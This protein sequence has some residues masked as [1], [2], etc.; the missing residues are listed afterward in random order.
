VQK[1]LFAYDVFTSKEEERP[2]GLAADV[3]LFLQFQR[4]SASA[5]LQLWAV[6]AFWRNVFSFPN[7]HRKRIVPN[8]APVIFQNV[9]EAF[10]IALTRINVTARSDAH[11]DVCGCARFDA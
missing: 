6:L 3:V 7:L 2:L 10:K 9:A 5:D 8:F 1:K 11:V 4:T